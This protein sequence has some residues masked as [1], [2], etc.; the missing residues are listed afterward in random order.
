MG[1]EWMDQFQMPR[2]RRAKAK[3][4]CSIYKALGLHY[5][6][7]LPIITINTSMVQLKVAVV[8]GGPSGLVTLK[9]LLELGDR[10]EDVNVQVSLFESEDAIGG[11]FRY[12]AYGENSTIPQL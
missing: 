4:P 6:T 1:R 8:G 7:V 5:G 12:R 11:T 3:K 9:T 10:H 2:A